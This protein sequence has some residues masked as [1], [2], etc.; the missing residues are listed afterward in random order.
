MSA[1][2]QDAFR[3]EDDFLRGIED[4]FDEASTWL[5]GSRFRLL[6]DDQRDR[7]RE[8][9]AQRRLPGVDLNLL[10]RLPNNRRSVLMGQ[11]RRLFGLWRRTVG[12]LTASVLTPLTEVLERS[13]SADAQWPDQ[14]LGPIDRATLVEH[15]EELT[16]RHVRT[17]IVGVCSPS[18]FT[19]D[20][21]RATF[22]R[23]GLTVVLIEPHA[24]GGWEVHG[25]SGP[26][27]RTATAFFDAEPEPE[28]MRRVR[29]AIEARRV[30]L[31]AEGLNAADLAAELGV[32]QG[33][34]DRAFRE[35]AA[36]DPGLSVTAGQ[37]G[38]ILYDTSTAV[39][40]SASMSVMD[41]IRRILGRQASP[42][43]KIKQLEKKQ[44]ELDDKR[45]ALQ[46]DLDKLTDREGE[47][48][49]KAVAAS[50]DTERRQF[51]SQLAQLR[52]EIG[53]QNEKVSI[54]NKQSQVLGRQI[55]NLEVAET[56]RPADLPKSEEITEAAA[57]AE[58]AL[59]ELDET[60][61]AVRTVSSATSEQ[62][63]TEEEA[64]I[65]AEIRAE[66]AKQETVAESPATEPKAETSVPEP[67]QPSEPE[68]ADD[69]PEREAT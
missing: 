3:I 6:T 24:S 66:V 61:E 62:G 1:T 53:L 26:D 12:M 22:R 42:A 8:Q 29:N 51:V 45:K 46:A 33:L 5:P 43:E 14:A 64:E 18:G 4:R 11:E 13:T 69:E 39:K 23:P 50:S 34:V 37:R 10:D 58:A 21:R 60:Y 38:S 17:H 68:R 2:V 30:E 31:V 36:S 47:L 49:Q 41:F 19:E 7:M 48:K 55:H 40:E 63:M 44:A 28:K 20:A 25:L 67:P 27:L 15:V 65:M 54:L 9:A 56:A 35:L 52:R 32:R 57:A 16:K 59:E